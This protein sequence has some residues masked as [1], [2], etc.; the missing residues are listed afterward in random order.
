MKL[1]VHISINDGLSQSIDRALKLNCDTFQIFTRNPRAWQ[2]KKIT[3]EEANSFKKKLRNSCIKPVFSHMPYI[4]NLCS[5]K[6]E[7]YNRSIKSLI[8]E[9]KRCERLSI[10]YIVTHIGSHL[11]T[12]AEKAY[13]RVSEA[14]KVALKNNDIYILLENA[15]GSTNQI[16]STFEEIKKIIDEVSDDQIGICFDTCHAYVA[17]IDVKSQI[18][19][20]ETLHIID[21][22]IG[23]DRIK[24]IH[25][26]DSVGNFGSHFDKHEHI[27]LGK[28]G[29][30]GVQ[31]ILQS[32]FKNYPI[33]L[34][35][36][37]DE[38][39]KDIDNLRTVQKLAT[40][41]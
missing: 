3:E 27:G 14:L 30:T 4:T 39:R 37:I 29:E 23:L 13:N 38:R 24:L 26:N 21:E 35:T 7:I 33:I 16:G 12:S 2:G 15:A 5:P 1:G 19:L 8:E 17:G 31:R 34:E 32:E 11:G 10:P 36:P 9:I 41:F 6:K 20:N 40:N 22:T 25:L 18:G 28:I